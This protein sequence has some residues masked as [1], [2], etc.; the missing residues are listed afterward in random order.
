MNDNLLLSPSLVMKTVLFS[1]YDPGLQGIVL[2]EPQIAS[3]PQPTLDL[4]LISPGLL[5]NAEVRLHICS[6]VAAEID[7]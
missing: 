4:Y 2:S 7:V 1:S 3:L 6:L 5:A